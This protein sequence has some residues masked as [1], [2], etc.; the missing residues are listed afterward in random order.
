MKIIKQKTLN[1]AAIFCK[2]Q[3]LQIHLEYYLTNHLILRIYIHQSWQWFIWLEYLN[4]PPPSL[5][6]THKTMCLMLDDNTII[7]WIYK[8][9]RKCRYMYVIGKGVQ[10]IKSIGYWMKGVISS[11]LCAIWVDSTKMMRFYFIVDYSLCH[12]YIPFVYTE[13]QYLQMHMARKSDFWEICAAWIMCCTD[14]LVSTWHS[15]LHYFCKKQQRSLTCAFGYICMSN[16]SLK[17]L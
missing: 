6:H 4:S 2:H 12:T 14:L 10:E 9:K 1:N 15:S 16:T 5:H 7:R 3:T 13:W 8:T 11:L 17:T